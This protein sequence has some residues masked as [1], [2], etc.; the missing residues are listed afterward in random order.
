MKQ[1]LCGALLYIAPGS[2]LTSLLSVNRCSTF[3][4]TVTVTADLLHSCVQSDS[5][6]GLL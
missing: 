5:P 1:K 3:E 6:F 2:N 4:M